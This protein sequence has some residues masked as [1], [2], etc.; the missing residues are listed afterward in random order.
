VTRSSQSQK[1][2]DNSTNTQITT[3]NNYG[4]TYDEVRQAALD[5]FKANF[6]DL[7]ALAKEVAEDR[8]RAI[9][10]ETLK[11]IFENN[12]E[13]VSNFSDPDI[14]AALLE[15]QKS[16]ARSGDEG[17]KHVLVE[18]IEQRARSSERTSK[19]ILLNEAIKKMDI[20]S[21]DDLEFLHVYKR[22]VSLD[23]SGGNPV[24]LV[25]SIQRQFKAISHALSTDCL[26][27]K[28]DFLEYAGMLNVRAGER[29]TLYKVFQKHLNYVFTKGISV[30]EF[31]IGDLSAEQRTSI[32]FPFQPI[33]DLTRFAIQHRESG[34]KE[35]LVENGWGENEADKLIAADKSARMNIAEI[36]N[37]TLEHFPNVQSRLDF[38]EAPELINCELTP[39][40]RLIADNVILA[41]RA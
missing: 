22:S 23:F 12:Q 37:F 34:Q 26:K 19:N 28:R 18:L 4:L 8:A 2:G 32:W 7:H 9:T 39:V 25:R 33:G 41:P 10:E 27:E 29:P 35:Y 13:A 40:A 15:A 36:K 3:Q 6:Y 31:A 17:A 30:K 20:L 14:A 24:I 16:Y 38:R 5:V 21:K 1:S 11:R